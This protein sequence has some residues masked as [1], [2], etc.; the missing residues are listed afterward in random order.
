MHPLILVLFNIENLATLIDIFML[1]NTLEVSEILKVTLPLRFK[2]K[3]VY[4]LFS[5]SQFT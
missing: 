1:L 4:F 3:F 2:E 5:V